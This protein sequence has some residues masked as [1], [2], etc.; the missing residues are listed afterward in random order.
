MTDRITQTQL[1][2]ALERL[3]SVSKRKY[4]LS[5]AYNRI[6]LHVYEK[7]TS[8]NEIT[9]HCHTKREMY[10]IIHGILTYLSF[11]NKEPI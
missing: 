7:G 9:S 11:E 3:N 2:Y 1:D 10:D 8:I 5:Y 6:A 4:K